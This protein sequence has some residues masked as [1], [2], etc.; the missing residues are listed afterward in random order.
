M[1]AQINSPESFGDEIKPGLTLREKVEPTPD[2]KPSDPY[3]RKTRGKQEM[4]EVAHVM[5]S[6]AS[7]RFPQAAALQK[8]HTR[9]CQVCSDAYDLCGFDARWIRVNRQTWLAMVASKRITR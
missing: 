4:D 6:V 5:G 1:S 9:V 8:V 7:L 3:R 2:E